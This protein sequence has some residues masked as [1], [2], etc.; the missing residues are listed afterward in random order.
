MTR[1]EQ[2]RNPR[3][4]FA[5]GVYEPKTEANVGVLMRSALVFGA[6][7]VFTIGRRYRRTAADTPNTPL[8]I[9][10]HH[11]EVIESAKLLLPE[12]CS[13]VGVE[14]DDRARYLPQFQHPRRAAYLLGSEDRGLP[15][16][17]M[18]LCDDI[19]QVPTELPFSLNVSAA[20]SIVLYD[21]HSK[22]L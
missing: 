11:Y 20:G 18:D 21:R 10:L 7:F 9:P 3:G 13:L 14:L 12:G 17:V 22:A 6:S 8:Q 4:Y 2:A 15:S 1:R 5:I 19:V 16:E